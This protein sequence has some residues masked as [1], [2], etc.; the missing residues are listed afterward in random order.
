MKKQLVVLNK[1]MNSNKS[2]EEKKF[3]AYSQSENAKIITCTL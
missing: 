3:A 1:K 2:Y